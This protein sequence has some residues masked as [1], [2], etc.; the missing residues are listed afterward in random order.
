ML[1]KKS[2]LVVMLLLGCGLAQSQQILL[3][4][5][6][7]F[8]NAP[9]NWRIAADAAADLNEKNNMTT[10]SGTGALVCIHPAGKYGREYDLFT[11][12]QHGDADLEFD[13]MMAKGSNSGVYLQ[14][15][16]EIQLF[17][18]WGT[19]QPR[20]YDVA[21]IYERWDESRPNGQK[22]YEGHPPRMNAC[23]A[24]GLWQ[25]LKVSFQAPRFDANGKKIANAKVLKVELNGA[26][27][28]EEV[29]LIGPTRG[30]L[31]SEVAA[32]P[33]LFQGDHGSVAFRNIVL[34]PFNKPAPTLKNLTYAYY[35]NV[36]GKTPDV[37]K[38]TPK[39]QGSVDGIDYNLATANKDYVLRFTGT[40][41]VPV[42]GKYTF[43]T[44]ERA[45]EMQLTVAN[46]N[47]VTW[48]WWEGKGTATLP[49]GDVPFEMLYYRSADWAQPSLGVFVEGEA[50]RSVP[51]HAIGSINMDK[52]VG[53]ILI[54]V[55][56][57]PVV[58]RSFL[59]VRNE[60]ISHGVSVG[61]PSG[62]HYAVNLE[63]GAL[64]RVWKGDFVDATP[65]WNDRGNG[66]SL[67]F[68]GILDL[69]NQP[70]LGLLATDQTT[71]PTAYSEADGHRF[72]GYDI[73]A[74]GRP[75]FKYEVADVVVKDQIKPDTENK[76]LEREL[77]I[78][79][80]IPAQLQCRLAIGKQIEKV[81][82]N[83]YIIDKQYYVKTT[84]SATIR[85]IANGQ[86]LLT[87]A[88]ATVSYAIIW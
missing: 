10:T 39:K 74:T 57:T 27:V 50:T 11:N 7:A 48:Q 16:Y 34:K 2:L 75:I 43:N 26:T 76:Y 23:R 72:R 35:E 67:P 14:G 46:Q 52:P 5:L 4:D 44:V 33:L 73:D 38:R 24:P 30:G 66:M 88:K 8:K 68:G 41:N 21:A 70:L 12:L 28:Q 83:L 49:A 22:G 61:D 80:T 32:G 42:A 82:D 84:G 51:L 6:S 19:K 69:Q 9:A 81:N 25:H 13:F 3:N 54:G 55:G 86:E 77:T 20:N 1:P 53:P 15:R 29:E 60:N 78:G 79:G 56:S 64:V 71:W 36:T 87:P 58:H 62:V 65:M 59:E 63:K 47:V 31:E 45:G 85:N 37:S 17:D 18:S 40:L